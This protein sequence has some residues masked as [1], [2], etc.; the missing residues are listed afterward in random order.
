MNPILSS[1]EVDSLST[2]IEE[3][4][5]SSEQGVKRFVEPTQ[6]ALRRAV[7]KRHHIVFGRRGSGKSSLLRKASADLTLT[8]TP[9]A[10]VDLESFKGHS[11]PDVL[12]SILIVTFQR[13]KEW[14]DTA[15]IHPSTKASFWN[16]F[17]ARPKKPAFNRKESNQLS[18]ELEKK[19]KELNDHLHS[20]DTSEIKKIVKK[21]QENSQNKAFSVNMGDAK[22]GVSVDVGDAKKAA[23]SAEIIQAY[24]HEKIAFLQRN[25]IEYQNIFRKIANLAKT[26]SYLFL[27]DLYH[28]RKID[29]PRV[30]DYFHSIGK[31][32]N[33]WLKVGTIKHRTQ[34]YVHGNPPVGVKLGDDAD[35]INLDLTL[36]RYTT[37]KTFL[38]R[39]LTTFISI[40][41]RYFICRKS[42]HGWSN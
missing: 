9:I 28:I 23:E 8:R 29:Q 13:F 7:S 41:M 20:P 38:L 12:L 16:L 14:L 10:F 2:L 27:D 18:L 21:D 24:H 31:G 4:T 5:R 11:Y 36:E 30:L 17:G 19:I 37:T 6:G 32:N 33:L 39:I 25:I 35:E 34:W 3:A 26:D 40:R 22:I 15:A 42:S 1:P